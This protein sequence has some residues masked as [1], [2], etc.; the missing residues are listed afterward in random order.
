MF[1]S[2][3]LIASG[4]S[5]GKITSR[6]LQPDTPTSAQTSLHRRR[7]QAPHMDVGVG[8]T[9]T[10]EGDH[11]RLCRLVRQL[12]TFSR[13]QLL[14]GRFEVLGPRHRRQGGVPSYTCGPLLYT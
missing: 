10:A 12:S 9:D 2:H 13:R 5:G 4:K 11:A 14:L 3:Y 8:G 7:T 6:M 1:T